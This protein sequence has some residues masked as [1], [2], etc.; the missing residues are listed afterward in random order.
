MAHNSAKGT[1]INWW[2][3]RHVSK[4]VGAKI[5]LDASLL[6]FCFPAAK[7]ASFLAWALQTKKEDTIAIYLNKLIVIVTVS[8]PDGYPVT[9]NLRICLRCEI[10]F[11]WI[12][13]TCQHYGYFRWAFFTHYACESYVVTTMKAAVAAFWGSVIT[14]CVTL[15]FILRPA[16]IGHVDKEHLYKLQTS[17]SVVAATRKSWSERSI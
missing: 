13:F 11:T 17:D 8:S 12:T 7:L 15:G 10:T 9:S 1:M 4:F 2:P 16:K 6:L 5:I 14:S 3:R